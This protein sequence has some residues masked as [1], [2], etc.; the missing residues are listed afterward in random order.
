[1]DGHWYTLHLVENKIKILYFEN[2]LAHIP[3]VTFQ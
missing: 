1:M 3:I 2:E